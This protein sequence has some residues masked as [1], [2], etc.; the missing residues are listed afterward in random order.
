MVI[1]QFA[2]FDGYRRLLVPLV[3]RSTLGPKM[4]GMRLNPCFTADGTLVVLH[5]L[6]MVS[7][8]LDQLGEHGGS[9]AEHGQAIADTLDEVFTRA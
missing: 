4:A 1:V 2:L 3:H 7:V 6:D 5:P 8:A 9:L